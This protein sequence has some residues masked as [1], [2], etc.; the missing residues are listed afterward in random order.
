MNSPDKGLFFSFLGLTIFGLVMMSS[1]SIAS[2]YRLTDENDVFFWRHFFHIVTAIPLF[3]VALKFPFQNIQ[4]LSPL[5]YIGGVILLLL[6]LIIGDSYGTAAKSWLDI[7][8][9]NIQP[10]EFMKF[11]IIVAVAAFFS[12]HRADASSL[13]YGFIPFCIIV[14]IPAFLIMLQPDFGSLMVLLVTAGSMYFVAGANIKHILGGTLVGA[15]GSLIVIFQNNY[16]L[17]RIK[18]FLNPDLDPLNTGFQVKQ[19]LIAIGSGGFFGRGFQNS[20]QKFDY[21]PE[22]QS[23]TIF[24]AIAEE[25]GFVRILFLIGIYLYIAYRGYHVAK[26]AP[27]EF[28]QLVALGITTWIVGQAFINIGVNMALLPNTGITLPLISAGGSSLLAT[29]VSFGVLLNIS[30]YSNVSKRRKYY[31]F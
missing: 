27:T 26:N 11:A 13:Q 19:A 5:V 1:M 16:I 21:L 4:K 31:S 3:L 15:L 9:M 24:S 18:V 20:I 7:G 12:S 17:H 22:V 14:G 23:D 10:V 29:I 28:S 8:V 6:T 30:Q 25:M 2:S